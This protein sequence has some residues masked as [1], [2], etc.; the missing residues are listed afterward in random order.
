VSP[1]TGLDHIDL[2]EAGRRGVEVLSLQG[3]AEFLRDVRA[4]AEHTIALIFALLRR[5]P[6]AVGHARDGG[7]SR[8]LF[9]GHELHGKTVGIVG[10][11]RV[12]SLV[13]RYLRAFDVDLL[14]SDPRAEP[15]SVPDDVQLVALD[16]L[17]R[18]ADLITVHAS[19]SRETERMFG[20]TQ[21]QSMKRGAWFINTSRGQL[22]DEGSLLDALRS[23]QLAGAAID[24][25]TGERETVER[26]HPLVRYAYAHDNLLLTPHIGGC[27]FE[28]ME[29]TERFMAEKLH[30]HWFGSEGKPA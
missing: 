18:E 25:R 23:G 11:G 15:T 6:S 30:R 26:K 22:V 13:A 10:F 12:G 5:I 4:T 24:V 3:E 8:D 9:K 1:T 2:V 20:R 19:L 28:S 29:K 21:F 7:W 27:T 17:L 16:R 14:A